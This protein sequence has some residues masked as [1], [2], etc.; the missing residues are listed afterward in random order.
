MANLNFEN[1]VSLTRKSEDLIK[2]VEDLSSNYQNRENFFCTPKNNS[3]IKT[4]EICTI[5]AVCFAYM[6]FFAWAAAIAV[7]AVLA[8]AWRWVMCK[9]EVLPCYDYAMLDSVNYKNI[10]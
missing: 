9:A 2:V 1:R 5:G 6:G 7:G 3:E 4:S 10:V 8:G